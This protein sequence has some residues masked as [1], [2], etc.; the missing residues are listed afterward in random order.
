ML[1]NGL[2]NGAQASD[3]DVTFGAWFDALPQAVGVLD[4][5]RGGFCAQCEPDNPSFTPDRTRRAWIGQLRGRVV[6]WWIALPPARACP[7]PKCSA[8]WM[9]RIRARFTIRRYLDRAVFQA[10]Q[11]GE[12][13]V[14]GDATNDA[15][16]EALELWR[17]DGRADQVSVVPVSAI[18]LTR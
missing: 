16:M 11:I 1:A 13:I 17:S 18:L 12:V 10:S 14:F 15:T 8:C 2:P 7:M 4:L 6:A 9:T 5:P 3:L